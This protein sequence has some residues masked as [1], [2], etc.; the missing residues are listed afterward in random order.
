[1]VIIKEKLDIKVNS[2]PVEFNPATWLLWQ[3]ITSK[4]FL[5]LCDLVGIQ[6]QPLIP[7]DR[8]KEISEFKVSP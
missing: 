3:G 5:G 1:M 8:G 4:D 2:A 6:T 7:G